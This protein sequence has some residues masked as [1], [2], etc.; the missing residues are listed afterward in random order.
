MAG[1]PKPQTLRLTPKGE[2]LISRKFGIPYGLFLALILEYYWAYLA[3]AFFTSLLFLQIGW[4]SVFDLPVLYLG[5]GLLLYWAYR[6][7][8]V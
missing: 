7:F 5:A 4:A 3:G 8:K 1:N 2:R 6:H